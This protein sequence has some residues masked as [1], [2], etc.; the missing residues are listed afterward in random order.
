MNEVIRNIKNRRSVRSFADRKIP[1]GLLREI[2]DCARYAPSGRNTQLWKFAVIA[3]SGMI[4]R[5]AG[6]TGKLLGRGDYDFY[7]PAALIIVACDRDNRL[8]VQD[9]SCALQNIFL[10]AASLGIGS[11]W[12]NQ[13][14]DVCDEPE[15]RAVLTELGIPEN[16]SVVGAAALG[17]PAEEGAFGVAEKK[18]DVTEYC[19]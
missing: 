16:Y 1:E 19:L 8:G 11:V 9:G 5:L 18:S 13:L 4:K 15:C 6:V 3:N 2:A 10:A 17:Y 12:I 7:G 14:H